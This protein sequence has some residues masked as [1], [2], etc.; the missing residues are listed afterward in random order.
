METRKWLLIPL[1]L[2]MLCA[3]GIPAQAQVD[4]QPLDDEFVFSL[5][6]MTIDHNLMTGRNEVRDLTA[7]KDYV[8][9]YYDDRLAMVNDPD[10]HAWLGRQKAQL[11]QMLD[12]KIDDRVSKDAELIDF[13]IDLFSTADDNQGNAQQTTAQRLQTI[14]GSDNPPQD[15]FEVMESM[16]MTD[17]ELQVNLLLDIDII[18]T[19]PSLAPAIADSSGWSYNVPAITDSTS[20][21]TPSSSDGNDGSGGAD[22]WGDA[23]SG[24]DDSGIGGDSSAPIGDSSAPISGGDDGGNSVDSVLMYKPVRFVNTGFEPVTVV[25]ETYDPPPGYEGEP[26]PTASTVVFPETNSSGLLNLP[27][28]IYTFCYYW[29]L[30]EDYNNDDYFDYHHR[31]TGTFTLNE[32]S[33]DN[34][35][36]ANAVTLTPDSVVSNPN[37]KCGESA[38]QNNSG[39]TSEQQVNQGTHTYSIYYSAPGADW[40]DGQSGTMVMSVIFYDGGAQVG[41]VDNT[42]YTLTPVGTNVYTWTDPENGKVQTYTFTLDG[43]ELQAVVS[44]GGEAY[45]SVMYATLSD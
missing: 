43:F 32:Y 7:L 29:Q 34:P 13:F 23:S 16:V 15:Y 24:D 30:D 19:Q 3:G 28:G 27:E 44:L 8:N 39:L 36:S 12:N 26:I 40:L 22:F 1:I 21:I 4:D 14:S 38:P 5:V 18:N 11:T 31:T 33:S 6:I 45:A 42:K 17:I 9:L 20:P 35:E 2:L 25:V 10:D 41:L 37:G